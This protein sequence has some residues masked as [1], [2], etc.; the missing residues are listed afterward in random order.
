MALS[1][2]ATALATL[3][4][5]QSDLARRATDKTIKPNDSMS[6]SDTTRIFGEHDALVCQTEDV[7]RRAGSLQEVITASCSPT[8]TANCHRERE[9]NETLEKTRDKAWKKRT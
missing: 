1:D 2:L 5:Q 3:R 6:E 9:Q 4:T 7:Q 8:K